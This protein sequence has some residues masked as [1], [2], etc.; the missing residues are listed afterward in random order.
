MV[1]LGLT[2]QT[3]LLICICKY[4]EDLQFHL[5][6]LRLMSLFKLFFKLEAIH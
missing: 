3:G 2:I 6:D 1:S 5:I 4:L